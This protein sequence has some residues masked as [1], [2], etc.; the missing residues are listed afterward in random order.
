LESLAYYTFLPKATVAGVSVM[1][2]RTGYT[3]EL[4]YELFCAASDA[5]RLWEALYPVVQDAGGVAVGLG[6]RDTLR[7]E[8][9]YVLYGNDIDETTTPLEAGLGWTVALDKEGFI[10]DVVLRRQRESGI[11][12][13]LVGF[14]MEGRGI[15]RSHYAIHADSRAIGTVTSGA[16][17][18]SLGTNIGLAYVETAY[19]RVGT[20]WNVDIRGKEHR[21]RVVKTPFY[22]PSAHARA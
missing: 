12:R 5:R 2:A 1:L 13:R 19:A 18:P 3:G 10:G 7:L 14:Q 9:R 21:A 20:A 17:S 15:A 16:P 6:A 8:M 4:G 11:R 22:M